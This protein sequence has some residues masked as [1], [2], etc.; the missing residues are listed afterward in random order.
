MSSPAELHKKRQRLDSNDVDGIVLQGSTCAEWIIRHG[1]TPVYEN[2]TSRSITDKENCQI[3]AQIDKN[4]STVDSHSGIDN[5][6]TV[7]EEYKSNGSERY[8][9]FAHN[10]IIHAYYLVYCSVFGRY[11]QRWMKFISPSTL[12]SNEIQNNYVDDEMNACEDLDV[13]S[14]NSHHCDDSEQLRITRNQLM[15][16][17]YMRDVC[18]VT[19]VSELNTVFLPYFLKQ[20]I[21]MVAYTI[22]VDIFEKSPFLQPKTG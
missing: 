2:P 12:S 9:A 5:N 15:W 7:G 13:E 16:L 22:S 8:Y 4:N 1:T 21:S 11:I 19:V 17:R 10:I 6:D 3:F 20:C 14:S 18:H